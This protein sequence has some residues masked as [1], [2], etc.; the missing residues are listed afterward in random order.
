DKMLELDLKPFGTFYHWDLPIYLANLG[1]W[2]KR[3]TAKYFADY[4]EVLMKNFGDRL[5]SVATINEPWCVAWLSHYLGVHAP[6][7]KDIQCTARAMHYIMLAHGYGM[8]VIRSYSHKNAGIVL[9]KAAVESY[10]DK[11]EDIN[12]AQLYEEIHNSWFS[13]AVFN[14]KYPEKILHIL[15]EYMPNEYEEDLKII[16]TPLDWLGINYYTRNLIKFD[17]MD[18]TFQLTDVDGP[19]E[20]TDMNWEV[21]PEG[22]TKIIEN[23]VEQYSIDIPIHI[24]ENGM[25]NKDFYIGG[26]VDDQKRID[27][28]FLHLQE[29]KTLIEK[30]FNIKSYFAW[31]L[32]DNFEWSFGYSKRF[33]LVYVDFES[34]KRIKKKS[35]HEF[36]KYLN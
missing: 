11:P 18:K 25:A 5:Y 17:G 33:G 7:L 24:T 3:D 36:A 15:H 35:W 27:Y 32:L 4:C 34:Q 6:G 23:E 2:A 31:S 28:Y 8:E 14:S 22:L 16:G 26:K 13:G 9:N 19:L 29:V 1:G 12:A 20:K 10:S 21:Y 30:G